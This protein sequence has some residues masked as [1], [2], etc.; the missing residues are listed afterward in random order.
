MGSADAATA[1]AIRVRTTVGILL[2]AL[3]VGACERVSGVLG[4]GPKA[5]LTA[6]LDAT[7]RGEWEVAYG[8]L[9]SED[10][11]VRSLAAYR[12]KPG[13]ELARAIESK[14]TYSVTSIEQNGDTAHAQVDVTVPDLS[15]AFADTMSGAFAAAFSGEKQEDIE[16]RVAKKL[17]DGEL[18]TTT[19]REEFTLLRQPEGWR[20][21]LDWETTDRIATLLAEATQ[22]KEEKRLNAALEKYD[23]VLELKGELV[24]AREAR[25]ETE[26]E[27]EELTEK[28][29]YI[30]KVALY[31]L[32]AR[33]YETYLDKRVAGV[34]F[35]LKNG[36]DRTLNEVEVTVYFK[37]EDG[38]VIAEED[39]HPVL[40]TK[41]SFGDNKPLKPNYIWQMERGKFYKAESVP[42]E[43]REGS[44]SA[45]ITDIEFAGQ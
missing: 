23:Q 10:Q 42:T 38:S 16:S 3:S 32:S 22:L 29:D 2:I 11:A 5:T 34:E 8:Y 20:I 1:K 18:P 39:Y 26:K 17:S 13:N 21:F 24:E 6:Y 43:W 19:K 4:G 41:Y 33:Y 36:G 30:E 9:S 37:A 40:V 15:G 27:I 25:A 31:D 44:V 35:K 12:A 28:Q 7:I 14:T 45:R